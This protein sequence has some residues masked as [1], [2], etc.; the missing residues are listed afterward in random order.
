MPNGFRRLALG[1]LLASPLWGQSGERIPSFD[2]RITVHPDG[3]LSV[4][5]SI[6]VIAMG[7]KI[8]HGIYRDFPT[9]YRDQLGNQYEVG[10]SITGLERDGSPEPYHTQPLSNGVRTYFGSDK[11]MLA[12]GEHTY[13]FEYSVTRELGFFRDHDELYWNVTGNGW[14]FPIDKATARAGDV[15]WQVDCYSRQPRSPVSWASVSRTMRRKKMIPGIPHFMPTISVF[16]RDSPILVTWPKGLIAPPTSEQKLSWFFQDN[17]ALL[18]GLVAVLS[19]W[20]YFSLA[21]LKVGRDPRPGT[22]M[23]LYEPPANLSPAAVRYL[24]HMQFDNKAFAAAILGLAAKGALKIRHDESQQYELIKNESAATT[25]L[26]PDESLLTRELFEDGNHLYLSP[27]NQGVITR[28]KKALSLSLEGS[29]QNVYFVTNSRY[30]WPG[31]C[32]DDSFC[33]LAAAHASGP[34]NRRRPV[35]DILAYVLDRRRRDIASQSLSGLEHR[36]PEQIASGWRA[37]RCF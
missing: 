27:E 9:Q 4:R 21:W 22:I 3:S 23:P 15:R 35:H 26:L 28:A 11:Q 7:R 33:G 31:I 2:S 24:K 34:E 36:D 32:P 19:V 6:T 1:L 37:G 10:F 16:I 5:E 25:K 20:G 17:Q 18:V 8:R 14:D 13:V 30:M 29:M 12:A